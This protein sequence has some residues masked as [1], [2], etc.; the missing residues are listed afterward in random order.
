[1]KTIF[2]SVQNDVLWFARAVWLLR[3]TVAL[4][5]VDSRYSE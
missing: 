3:Q 5:D 1:M 2:K 4:R